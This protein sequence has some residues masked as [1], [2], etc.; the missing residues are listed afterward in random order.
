MP[1]FNA[2][3]TI[4]QT[5]QSIK[6]LQYPN[7]EILVI[8]DGST[9][10]TIRII[11]ENYDLDNL[12]IINQQN[13]GVSVARNKGIKNSNGK[14]CFFIDSDDSLDNDSISKMVSLA[15]DNRLNLVCCNYIELNSTKIQINK[16]DS[17]SFIA[18]TKKEISENYDVFFVQS[19]CAKLINLSFIRK[20]QFL[21]DEGMNLGEDLTFMLRILTVIDKIGYVGSSAYKILNVNPASLSKRYSSGLSKDIEI[22]YNVWKKLLMFNSTF[23]RIYKERHISFELYLLSV[24]FSNLFLFD[25]DI[26]NR[27]KLKLI[28]NMLKTHSKWVKGNEIGTPQN[29][30]QYV[31]CNV[32]SNGNKYLIFFFFCLKE[33][34]RRAKFYLGR[35]KFLE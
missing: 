24:Y 20:H 31:M 15:E 33:K 6:E 10:D 30:Y 3:N 16:A 22:Q 18:E 32:I 21:F 8:N 27:I 23:E 13:R 28:D 12:K 35:K 5:I 17:T 9:D 34:L 11:R 14:Y 19:A 29:K 2:Q 7:L 1:V 25:C 26:S 4:K